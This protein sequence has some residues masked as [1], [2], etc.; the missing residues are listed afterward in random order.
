MPQ[1]L[2][3]VPPERAFQVANRIWI[4]LEPGYNAPIRKFHEAASYFDD[5]DEENCMWGRH[6]SFEQSPHFETPGRPLWSGLVDK[7][8]RSPQATYTEPALKS[9]R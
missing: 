8:G 1:L 5:N 4:A 7:L 9:S 2:L 3:A 6:Q